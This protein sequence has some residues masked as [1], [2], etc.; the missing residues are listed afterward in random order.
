M[1]CTT[2]AQAAARYGHIDFASRHWPDQGKWLKMLEIP[3]E[4]FPQWRVLGTKIPVTHIAC[5]LDL[6][7]PLL[8]A[9]RHVHERGLGK[10]LLT[11]DGC[12]NIRMVRGSNTHFSTHSYGLGLD[13]NAKW[14][15]MGPVLHTTWSKAFVKCFTEQGFDWGGDWN[16]R[17]DPMHFS[18]A[19]E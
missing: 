15:P 17:K 2:R 9:L 7:A 6:H 19:W 8:T 18:L 5:N 16:G 3:P 12:F 4:W 1:K 13:I 10:E 14:N 11:F